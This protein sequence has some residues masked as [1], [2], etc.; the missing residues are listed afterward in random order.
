MVAAALRADPL[1]DGELFDIRILIPAAGAGLAA[2]EPP[3]NQNQPLKGSVKYDMKK[4]P[5]F[6]LD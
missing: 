3:M 6:P 5:P 2:R 4:L 1:P